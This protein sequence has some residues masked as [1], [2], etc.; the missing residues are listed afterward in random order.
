[1]SKNKQLIG[2]VLVLLSAL[3]WGV[4]PMIAKMTYTMGNNAVNM[5]FLRNFI[6]IP[7][8]FV[9]M[10]FSKVS[11]KLEAKEILLLFLLGI[12]NAFTTIFLYMSY[13]YISI[14]VATT[15]NCS[16]PIFVMIGSMLFLKQR[17]S[18]QKVISLIITM[19]GIG[20]FFSITGNQS[21]VLW[22]TILAIL[23]SLCYTIYVLFFDKTKLKKYSAFKITFYICIVN[24][25]C[26]LIFG[27]AQNQITFSLPLEVWGYSIILAVLCSVMSITFFQLGIKYI[28]SVT[29]SILSMAE[30]ITSIIVGVVFLNE[31]MTW[32]KLVGCILI[33]VGILSLQVNKKEKVGKRIENE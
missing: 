7:I 18:K 28:G 8:L 4:T 19:I 26:C 13:S 24:S 9:I 15:L 2:T 16:Y 32:Q 10:L 21:N 27:L 3:F 23:S 14:G 25:I 33:I 12:F 31:V 17:S 1:M 22:G 29:T 20:M 6:A 30:P 5:A 11:F